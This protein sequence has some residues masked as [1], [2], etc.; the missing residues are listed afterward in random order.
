MKLIDYL[1]IIIHCFYSKKLYNYI[2]SSWNGNI[3]A[4]Y[5]ILSIIMCL[6]ICLEKVAI[7]S[8]VD[9]DKI[10][11][12]EETTGTNY[13]LRFILD[14]VPS[15]IIK[16]SEMQ[17]IDEAKHVIKN[18]QGL[19][20]IAFDP[21][22]KLMGNLDIENNPELVNLGKYGIFIRNINKG[23]G[24]FIAYNALPFFSETAEYNLNKKTVIQIARTF[25]E[26]IILFSSIYAFSIAFVILLS[27]AVYGVIYLL[28][29]RFV[30][31]VHKIR[32]KIKNLYILILISQT[33]AVFVKAL[34]NTDTVFLYFSFILYMP[35]VLGVTYLLFA[36]KSIDIAKQ[37]Q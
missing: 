21:Q 23:D 19:P 18:V 4:Y 1:K 14:Q 33:P 30:Y 31:V 11:S 9:I 37:S 26:N 16:N 36:L 29:M 34:A 7:F 8:Q 25:K 22:Q 6:P 20:I 15:V 12:A 35:L 28:I 13:N 3:F 10:V 17:T 32:V 24:N 2:Y 27:T 5:F